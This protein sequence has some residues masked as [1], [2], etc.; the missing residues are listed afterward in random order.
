MTISQIPTMFIITLI[1]IL[2]IIIKKQ[3]RLKKNFIIIN[4][5]MT[6]ITFTTLIF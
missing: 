4:I 2:I 5:L 6:P 1:T 3:S